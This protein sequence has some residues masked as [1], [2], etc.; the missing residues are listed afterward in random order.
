MKRRV[1]V[2]LSGSGSNLQALIEAC[3]DPG[4]PGE[5][6]VVISN[7]ADAYGLER[8]RAAGIPAVHVGHRDYASRGD[9]EDALNAQ[10][11]SHGAEW[12]ACA[13]FMRILTPRFLR[14][15]PL[16]VL[17]IHPSLLPAF[18]GVDAQGQAHDHGVRIAGATVHLVDEG[19]DTGPIVA[20]AAVAVRQDEDRDALQRRILK[21]E[22]ELYPMALRI[23]LEG[24]AERQ[25][26]GLRVALA[27]GESL[28][29][30]GG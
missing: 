2:L 27:E 3:A 11:R 16:R 26:R 12:V 30:W 22:H 6:A 17:N 29:L 19:T 10:L 13:G 25:G 24:R 9:F 21:M 7:R 15:W 5:I 20:Q 28:L 8:A 14:A 1:G 23:L 4:Y 18:P